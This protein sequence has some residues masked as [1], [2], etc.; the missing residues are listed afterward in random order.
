M[1]EALERARRA[2]HAFFESNSGWGEPTRDALAEWLA[3]GVCQCP[4]E[5]WVA[6]LGVCEHGLAS[7]LAVLQAMGEHTDL[8]PPVEPN[9][10]RHALNFRDLAGVRGPGGRLVAAGRI[11]RSG[12]LDLLDD[13]DRSTLRALGLRTVIDLRADEERAA[14]VNR[15][16]AEV[17]ER[18]RPVTDVSA[19]PNTIMERIAAGDTDGLGAEMLIRGNRHFVEAQA[20]RFGALVRELLDP[21]EQPAVVHCTAGKDRTGFAVACVLWTIG[22][23]HEDVV[24]DYLR[25]NEIMRDQHMHTLA[26]AAERG[27]NTSKLEEMLVVRREYLDSAFERAVELHG[28]IDAF[29]TQGLGIDDA[30]RAAAAA[31]L[32]T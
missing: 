23:D 24:A 29:V 9:R 7:W 21:N 26:A 6:P 4:D 20:D 12:V 15:L 13:V 32:L 8:Q 31:V 16:P 30:D 2:T 25:T 10:L 22:V 28:S 18:H 17:E 11:F 14:R 27:I 19:H 3:D 5:C 1:N